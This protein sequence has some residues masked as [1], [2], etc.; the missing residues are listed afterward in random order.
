MRQFRIRTQVR[1]RQPSD[2]SMSYPTSASRPATKRLIMSVSA[3]L[4]MAALVGCRNAAYTDLYVESMAAEI[5]QLEDQLYE[6][7]NEYHILEQELA[8]LQAENQLLRQNPSATP[9]TQGGIRQLLAPKN[10]STLE[11]SPRDT[12]PNP[13]PRN[14]PETGNLPAKQPES[15]L[16][17]PGASRS[18]PEQQRLQD[19]LPQLPVEPQRNQP[20]PTQPRPQSTETPDDL[21]EIPT[22]DPG[23]PLPPGMPVLKDLS[24]NSQPNAAPTNNL[25]LNLSRIDIP[26]QLTSSLGGG[27]Q[28]NATRNNRAQLTLGSERPADM[29]I[30]E[31][32]FH[33]TL[34]RAAN[35]DD[36]SDDDGLYLVLQ[37][38][39]VEGQLVPTFADLEVAVIDPAREG[40]VSSARI[41]R[42][43]YSAVEVKAKFHPIGSSQ[44]IHLTLPWNGPDP[45]GDRVQVFI[46]YTL[47]DGRQVV[48]DKT[49]F[50]SG[51]SS[52]RTVWVPRSSDS[53]QVVTASGE[54]SRS[55]PLNPKNIV[56]AQAAQNDPAPSPV[57]R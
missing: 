36:E 13:I 15:I 33:P 31:I 40:D 54:G 3:L 12:V 41:G 1:I 29:R 35:F 5:R 48:N 53:S 6:Y 42:W 26:N 55:E 14:T 4:F 52:M 10:S 27:G 38:K 24:A 50:V 16:E 19:S 43:N 22:I 8:S 51:T 30:V 7:D 17:P 57:I 37:P 18:A 34:T 23:T 9:P 44:G 39:N 56:G 2:G 45:S 20:Q 21:L 28:A 11:F 25:E 47:P 46:R 49:I 32:A